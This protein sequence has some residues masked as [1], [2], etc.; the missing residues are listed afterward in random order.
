MARILIVDDQPEI[1]ELLGMSLTRDGHA[2]SSAANGREALAA[3][4]IEPSAPE[5]ALPEI[6]LLDVMMPVMDGYQLN[7]RLQT[8]P[9]AKGV[10]II[11][12]TA[13]GQKMRDLFLAA[14]NVAAYL[15]KPFDPKTLRELIA[16]ILSSNAR[17]K[18]NA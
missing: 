1:V 9:R 14:P 10:P 11:V 15:Q 17:P 5:A 6:V 3:M 2:V 8:E 18:S 4:G 16:G 7:Q 13:R 12:M